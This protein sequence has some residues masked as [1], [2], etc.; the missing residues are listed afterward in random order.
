MH[1]VSVGYLVNVY[2][3]VTWRAGCIVDSKGPRHSAHKPVWG[4]AH[5]RIANGPWSLRRTASLWL[6]VAIS[7]PPQLCSADVRTSHTWLLPAL[8]VV[9]QRSRDVWAHASWCE[10][11]H[12]SC[13]HVYWMPETTCWNKAAIPRPHWLSFGLVPLHSVS[14]L[15]CLVCFLWVILGLL[16]QLSARERLL[17]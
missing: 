9:W 14:W 17:D 15:V 2:V 3:C 12:L 7:F 4:I 16:A 6:A 8:S 11:D 10:A 5:C 1:E 13:T